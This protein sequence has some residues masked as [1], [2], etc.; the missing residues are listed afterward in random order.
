LKRRPPRHA[1]TNRIQSTNAVQARAIKEIKEIKETVVIKEKRA[2][3][4]AVA[5]LAQK[6][7]RAIRGIAVNKVTAGSAVI[8][9]IRVIQANR[10]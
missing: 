3:K 1:T 7:T 10:D 8:E 2:I 4:H 6:E 9:V 5:I